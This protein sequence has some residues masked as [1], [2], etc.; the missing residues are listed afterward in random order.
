M[1]TP[2][3]TYPGLSRRGWTYLG[4]AALALVGALYALTGAAMAGSFAISNYREAAHWRTVG[5]VYELLF[6]LLL[7]GFFTAMVAFVRNWRRA[8]PS[9]G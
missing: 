9:T 2:L 6:F 5:R 8:R 1:T 7:G 4:L 3:K